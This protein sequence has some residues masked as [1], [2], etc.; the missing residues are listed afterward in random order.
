MIRWLLNT[1]HTW[2]QSWIAK[3]VNTFTY[4]AL[5]FRFFIVILSLGTLV[6]IADGVSKVFFGFGLLSAVQNW[7]VVLI[8]FAV[9]Y[10]AIDLN[11]FVLPSKIMVYMLTFVL[12][13]VIWLYEGGLDGSAPYLFVIT[14][15]AIAIVLRQHKPQVLVICNL[16]MFGLLAW[17][18]YLF[19][20]MIRYHENPAHRILDATSMALV[21]LLFLYFSLSQILDDY[22][23]KVGQLN[24]T[25][26][27]LEHLSSID[28]LTG[29]Y[30]RRYA[31]NKFTMVLQNRRRTSVSVIMIDIDHFKAINDAHGHLVGDKTLSL[32]ATI[33]SAHTRDSDTV[34]RIGGEEFLILLE[35]TDEP[36]ARLVANNLRQTILDYSHWPKAMTVTASFGVFEIDQDKDVDSVLEGVDLL[37]YKAKQKGRNCVVSQTQLAEEEPA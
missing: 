27:R 32:L 3:L 23:C 8:S 25:Q 24:E 29:L 33:L 30:N 6:G 2:A 16:C 13:P 10:L 17:M 1:I 7:L 31:M 36:Q 14:V 21:C 26:Q 12:Y 4:G 11:N 22:K 18:Q 35:N 28:S 20:E 19:P 37:L 9:L 15:A 5:E 34:A